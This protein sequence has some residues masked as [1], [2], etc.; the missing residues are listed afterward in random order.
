MAFTS[1]QR[2]VAQRAYAEARRLG[3]SPREAKALIAAGLVESNLQHDRYRNVGSGD[4]D[5][6]G[7]LQQRP[8]MGWGP[9][10]ESIEQDTRQFLAAAKKINRGG[11]N[12][13]AGQLAQAVQR[14]AFP[15]RYDQRGAEAER[16]L[17]SFSGGGSSPARPSAPSAPP[18]EAPEPLTGGPSNGAV[19]AAQI[20]ARAPEPQQP[21]PSMGI[22]TP[23]FAAGPRLPTGA[24]PVLSGAGQ[25]PSPGAALSRALSSIAALG[26]QEAA[27]EAPEA[28]DAPS[29]AESA[30]SGGKPASANARA[31]RSP[32]LE[33]FWQ[34]PGGI[35]VKNGK[36]VP[37]GFVDGHDRH[38]H[39]AAGPKTV[40]DLAKIAQS[41]GLNVGEHPK[42]GGVAAGAHVANSNHYANRAIDVT[43]SPAKLR[44]Y[45]RRIARE[46]GIK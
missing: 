37:Q 41:M 24:A 13:S 8:S 10:G 35:N 4:R 5:S 22:A 1:E 30:T 16:L 11:F 26:G 42:F 33:L 43:G 25:A 28:A 17:R 38:V 18:A 14:S 3:A 2:R 44:A 45:A 27:P 46:Y 29:G 39:V 12:G 7:F 36:K 31:G 9:P 6:V 23:E 15:A 34:G 19:L 32:L 21:R 20:L 40:L